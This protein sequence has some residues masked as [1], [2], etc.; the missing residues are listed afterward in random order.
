M[1]GRGDIRL[2][3]GDPRS[4]TLPVLG[5]ITVREDTRRLRRLLRCGP[6]GRP[7]AKILFVTVAFERGHWV[8]LV[9]TSAPAFHPAMCH[10]P[11]GQVVGIDLGLSA[12]LVAAR[13]NREELERVPPPKALLAARPRLQ[14]TDRELSRKQPGSARRRQA[15]TKRR[16]LRARR[17]DTA[18]FSP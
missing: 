15:L 1:G 17:G 6:D 13:S 9:T 8:L 12:F 10:K 16:E 3:E 11:S 18:P 2:G 7:R 5:V 4:I 14:R